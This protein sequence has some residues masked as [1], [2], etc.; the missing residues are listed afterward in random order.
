MAIKNKPSVCAFLL[1]PDLSDI[2]GI[3]LYANIKYVMELNGLSGFASPVH[4]DSERYH[5]HVMVIRPS[6]CGFTMSTW[7][8]IAD[9]LNAVNSHVEVILSPH[10]YARYLLHLDNPEKEQFDLKS[11]KVF[12]NLDYLSYIKI[13]DAFEKVKSDDTEIVKD[14]LLY[15]NTYSVTNFTDLVDFALDR[16]I[17]WIPTITNRHSFFIHYMRSL[18]YQL[19]LRKNIEKRSHYFKN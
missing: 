7:R 10:K 6:R 19:N 9:C 8:E 13:Q 17:N 5:V 2:G 16:S 12:G 15:I 4:H 14:I 3:Q 18:E 11:I 1:Y